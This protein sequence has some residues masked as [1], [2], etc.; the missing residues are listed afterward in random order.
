MTFHETFVA[1]A[2]SLIE[3]KIVSDN[4]N[5]GAQLILFDKTLT[6]RMK[7]MGFNEVQVNGEFY[8]SNLTVSADKL[9]Y[10]TGDGSIVVFKAGLSYKFSHAI[11]PKDPA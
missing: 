5:I 8:N 4:E 6:E 7:T 1:E 9:K 2:K 11:K 3:G 10:E